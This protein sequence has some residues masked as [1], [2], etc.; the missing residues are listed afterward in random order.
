[1]LNRIKKESLPVAHTILIGNKCDWSIREITE[2]E[3][4]NIASEKHL[5]YS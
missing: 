4:K 1:M 5:S 3:K 2:E